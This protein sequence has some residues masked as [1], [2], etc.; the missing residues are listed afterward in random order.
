MKNA[1][2]IS[3]IILL[4]V[5][6]FAQNTI[7]RVVKEVEKNNTTLSAYRKIADAAKMGNKTALY[8]Q[9]PEVEFNYL[10]GNPSVIG[11]RTDFSIKQSFDFPT[12]YAFK[13]QISDLENEQAELEY[14]KQRKELLLQARLICVELTYH[15]AM[16]A[17]LQNRLNDAMQ[18]A[19]AYTSKFNIGEVSILEHNKAQINLL[20]VTK[21]L[22]NNGIERNTLLAELSM[23]NG[24][25]ALNFTDSLFTSQ[26]IPADFEQW[27]TSVEANNP[28]LQWIRHEMAISEKQIDLNAAMSLP[29][30]H[31]GYMSEN[32]V[33]EQFRGVTVGVTIPLWENKNTVKYA[34]ANR[35]AIQSMEADAKLQYYSQMKA[36]HSKAVSLQIAV[37]EYRQSLQL[38]QNAELLKK[39]FDQGEI[40][41]LNYVLEISFA[42]ATID[43]YLKA[44]HELNRTITLLY[45]Y[46]E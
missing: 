21:E 12:A 2:M 44:E 13:N 17:E 1:L 14:Q 27:L 4:G 37:N 29:K 41:L 43:K 6:L 9:N 25:N 23:L 5:N 30:F 33:V 46:R 11:N 7:D 39:A 45:Q 16:N 3:A 26:T 8:P 19:N 40:S 36:L 31:A 20:N 34:K 15:N 10:W 22:E 28:V 35:I 38:Y 18:I 24:G 32:V 42:Y